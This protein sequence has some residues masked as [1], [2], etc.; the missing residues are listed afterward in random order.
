MGPPGV[1]YAAVLSPHMRSH[2]GGEVMQ[3]TA[4]QNCYHR[5]ITVSESLSARQVTILP[6]M[7]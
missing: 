6:E 5:L 2:G 1:L 7:L 3:G 4:R